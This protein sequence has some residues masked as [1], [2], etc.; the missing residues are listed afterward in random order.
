MIWVTNQKWNEKQSIQKEKKK[1]EKTQTLQPKQN[2]CYFSE[3][4][5]S[6]PAMLALYILNGEIREDPHHSISTCTA[7]H[8]PC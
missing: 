6:W 1:Q 2:I 3:N 4:F 7:G 8:K 5:A